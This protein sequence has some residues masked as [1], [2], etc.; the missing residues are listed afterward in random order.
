MIGVKNRRQISTRQIAISR[1]LRFSP[2]GKRKGETHRNMPDIR[3][4][5][6]LSELSEAGRVAPSDRIYIF[7]AKKTDSGIEFDMF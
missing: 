5:G 4:L 2:D 7:T 3:Q 6:L 1:S